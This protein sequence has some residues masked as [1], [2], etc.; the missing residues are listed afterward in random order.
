[1][2]VSIRLDIGVLDHLLPLDETGLSCSRRASC[3]VG[4][5]F[6]ADV[7]EL[8]LGFGT[9]DDL[10]QRAVKLA[11]TPGGVPAGATRPAQASRLKPLRPNSSMVGRS[12]NS[13]ERLM[14]D[15]ASARSEPAATCGIAVVKSANIIDTRPAMMSSSAG[16]V[17]V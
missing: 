10:A 7:L 12:G 2:C 16:G 4:E 5:A 3:G 1:M 8:L 9:V 6:E 17:L 14:R 13:E 15:T 11:T